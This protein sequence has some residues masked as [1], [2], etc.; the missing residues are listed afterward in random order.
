MATVTYIE[1][2]ALRYERVK[3]K[4]EMAEW[5]CSP[6]TQPGETF[7]I[8]HSNSTVLNMIRIWIRKHGLKDKTRQFKTQVI[9][10]ADGRESLIITRVE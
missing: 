4:D 8:I 6:D 5:A 7:H 10:H 2:T 9:F 1:P 3:V